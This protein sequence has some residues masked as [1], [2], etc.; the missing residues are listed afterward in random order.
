MVRDNS[1]RKTE[2][3]FLQLKKYNK[4][5]ITI[6][7]TNLTWCFAKVSSGNPVLGWGNPVSLSDIF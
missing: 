3:G 2:I 1:F 4:S 6:C 5:F 7:S